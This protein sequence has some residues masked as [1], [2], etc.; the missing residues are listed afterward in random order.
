MQAVT[1]KLT[2]FGTLVKLPFAGDSLTAP[3]A[4]D[5]TTGAAAPARLG[6][7][8]S[9]ERKHALLPARRRSVERERA[10]GDHPERGQSQRALDVAGTLGAAAAVDHV[11]PRLPQG[12]P[13]S[14]R[15][16]QVSADAG[17]PLDEPPSDDEPPSEEEPPSEDDDDD[18]RR[19]VAGAGVAG[20]RVLR[21]ARPA[22]VVG[23]VE[24]GPLVVNRHRMEHTL[25]RLGTADLAPVRARIRHAVE[26]LQQMPVRALVL[27]DRHRPG[28]AS[29]GSGGARL[30]RGGAVLAAICA[31]VLASAEAAWGHAFLVTTDPPNGSILAGPPSVVTATFSSSVRVGSRNAAIRNADGADVLGGEPYIRGSRVLVIPLKPALRD[32]TYTVRWSIVSDDGHRGEGLIAFGIGKGSGAPVAALGIQGSVTWQQIVMRSIFLLG[33]LGALGAAAFAVV[34]LRPLEAGRDVWRRHAHVLFLAFLLSFAGADAL[35]HDT[36]GGAT[37]FE[38]WLVVAAVTSVVGAAAAAL[39]PLWAPLLYVGWAA[40]A[41]V[42]VCPTLSGHALD[43]DQPSLIAPA[44][45]LLHLG[46]AGIWVG[47]LASLVLV[48]GRAPIPTRRAA[49]RRFSAIAGPAVLVVA[50]AGASRALTELTAVSQLWTT[51][52]G[53]VLL[54]KTGL[55]AVLVTLGYLGRRGLSAAIERL[56]GIM[57]LE[58]ALLSAV[59]VA[60]GTLTA[61]RPGVSRPKAAT[62]TPSVIR[63]PPPAPPLGAF[64]DGAQAGRLAVGFAYEAGTAIVTLLGPDGS[65]ATGVPVSIGGQAPNRCGRGCFSARVPGPTIPVRVGATTLSFEVP[66]VLRRATTELRGLRR[67]Y[68]SL[69]ALTIRERLSSR[70]G[71][72]QVTEFRERAPDRM[73]FRITAASNPALVG[74]EGVVIGSRRWDRSPGGQWTASAQAPLRVPRA[75]WTAKARNAFFVARDEITF[76]DPSFPGWFRVRFDPRTGHVRTL[77]MFAMAHF[78]FHA[79]SDFDRPVSISPPSR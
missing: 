74:T 57:L 53:R 43:P 11:R 59:V 13:A 4:T 1:A 9:L 19:R 68:E 77:N 51:S 69:S 56:E 52:Y 38:Q 8:A 3:L 36:A 62:A 16:A 42:A 54:L 12:P 40:A 41:V 78:M 45:D 55:F 60:V 58:L 32:G 30:A 17:L 15:K 28:K 46:A 31:L 25:E 27:V 72:M 22:A 34:V 67:D 10:V 14:V 71:S 63:Q 49:A 79:Y 73:A 61:L 37:R 66:R 5:L 70:P 39:A 64:V 18:D 20:A 29:S 44:A 24:A 7:E 2:S 47:G 33:V 76:Y 65:G 23:R 48:L 6:Q 50:A 26:D 75:Y 21:L 35:I